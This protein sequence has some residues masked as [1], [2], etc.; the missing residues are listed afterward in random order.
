[1]SEAE[2]TLPIVAAMLKGV[3]HPAIPNWNHREELTA[4]SIIAALHLA[5]REV[6][7]QDAILKKWLDD[8]PSV[9]A[10][11]DPGNEKHMDMLAAMT[12]SADD[13]AARRIIESH[14]LYPICRAYAEAQ[15]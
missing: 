3:P 10:E 9:A 15:P 6:I 1:M 12:G 4:D 8:H 14:P 13:V 2:S 11:L 5:A 7:R